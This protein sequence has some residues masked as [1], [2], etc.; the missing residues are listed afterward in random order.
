MD[1]HE[2][3]P[4]KALE[5]CAMF[6][7]SK[8][9]KQW[10]HS[11]NGK[12][13][14]EDQEELESHL[15][16]HFEDLKE[17]GI[18]E[19]QAFNQAVTRMGSPE[20]VGREFAKVRSFGDWVLD[21]FRALDL[22]LFL[23]LLLIC[24]MG[25]LMIYS[26]GKGTG[27]KLWIKQMIWI[28]LGF[29]LMFLAAQTQPV[30]LKRCT[31]FI[32]G[33]SILLLILVVFA[34]KQIGGARRWFLLGGL[35]IQ[36][37]V[38]MILTLPMMI[39]WLL[40]K[41]EWAKTRKGFA[42]MLTIILLPYSLILIQ[43]DIS[44]ALLCL[45]TGCIPMFLSDS[46]SHP[47]KLTCAAMPVLCTAG[48][49]LLQPHQLKRILVFLNPE[50]DS[51]GV[52][53]N[54][55]QIREAVSSGGFLGRGWLNAEVDIPNQPTDFILTIIAE[56]FGTAGVIVLMAC[57][58]FLLYRAVIISKCSHDIFSRFLGFGFVGVFLMQLAVHVCVTYGWMPIMGVPLP[59]VSYG[60]SSLVLLLAGFGIL[61]SIHRQTRRESNKDGIY[62]K[63]T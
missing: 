28:G 50:A 8:A 12:C 62:N 40:T 17:T 42:T 59:L 31:P 46:L 48:W 10:K 53:Y 13:S 7:L 45:C 32:Y 61:A 26:A 55:L 9:I 23:G 20:D 4:Y 33:V 6:D 38:L 5:G 15:R 56:Q 57:F 16:E 37:S 34:G 22:P 3:G 39:A 27:A 52:G 35:A 63:F 47:A 11:F 2:Q 24:G 36:P 51:S 29:S 44:M 58:G 54:I 43:P 49:L 41:R 60:G 19:D 18:S 21:R 14:V 25:L 30:Q 1:A